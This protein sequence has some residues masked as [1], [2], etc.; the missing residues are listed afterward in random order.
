MAE[1]RIFRQATGGSANPAAASALAKTADTTGEVPAK[2]RAQATVEVPANLDPRLSGKA[3]PPELDP[4]LAARDLPPEFG[5]VDGP[6]P[7][8]Y[9]DWEAKGRCTDF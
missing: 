3:L 6:E 2:A 9:G 8:R 4:L 7:T 5:G 1:K